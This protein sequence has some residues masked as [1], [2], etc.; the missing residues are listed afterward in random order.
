MSDSS[1][2]IEKLAGSSNYDLW[3]I[4]MESVLVEKGYYEVMT[5]NPETLHLDEVEKLE[6]NKLA[7]KATAQIRLALGNGPLLQTK[8][9][10]NPYSL[11]Q[12][13]KQLYEPKGFSSEFLILKELFSTTLRNSKYD[14]EDYL[15]TIKRLND[16]LNARE[17]KLPIKVIIAWVLN[18]L[19]PDYENTVAIITQQIRQNKEF[20]LEELF[21]YLI[22]EAR[23]LKSNRNTSTTT[24][25]STTTSD[26]ALVSTTTSISNKKQNQCSFCK[27]N[28][29]IEDNCFKKNPRLRESY[30]KKQLESINN[31]TTTNSSSDISNNIQESALNTITTHSINYTEAKNISITT[32]SNSI[33]WVLDSGASTHICADKE[34]FHTIRPT[35]S[36]IKWGSNNAE[37]KASGIGEIKIKFKNTNRLASLNQVL[38][39]PE[40]GV[41]LISLGII[42][43]KG[44]MAKF[45]KNSCKIYN[46][47]FI[48]AEG[49]YINNLSIFETTTPL[50]TSYNKTSPSIILNT[51]TLDSKTWHERLGHIGSNALKELENSTLGVH[52]NN[53]EF[54]TKEC[55]T[56]IQAKITKKVSKKPIEKAEKYLDKVYSDIGGPIFPSTNRGYKYYVTLLDSNTRYLEV[57]L[58]STKDEIKDKLPLI[59]KREENISENRLKVFFSDNAK[60]YISFG[61]NYLL[62]KGVKHETSA[63]YSPDQNGIAERINRTLFNK[64]RALLIQANLAKKYWGEALLSAV[65]LYN[66]TP[67]SSINYKT[68]YELK[69]KKKPDISSLKKWGSLC[70]KREDSSLIS[71]LDS[72]AT[73]YYIIGY[74][75]NQYKLL[76]PSTNRILWARDVAIIEGIYW[77]SD[78]ENHIELLKDLGDTETL[79]TYNNYN[80]PNS[81]TTSSSSTSNIDNKTSEN[82]SNTSNKDTSTNW[83]NFYNELIEESI[84]NTSITSEISNTSNNIT[85]PTSYKQAIKGLYQDNWKKAMESELEDH[86]KLN[87]WTLV[88]RPKNQPILGGRWVYKAKLNPDSSI[89]KFKARWVAKGYLQHYGVNYLETFANTVR[90]DIYRLLFA[91][92]SK[93][94]LKIYQWDVKLAFVN[95]PIDTTIYIEL[96]DGYYSSSNN[97][98]KNEDKDIVCL[99]NKALYGLKQSARQW[100]LYLTS[101]LAK[102][103][104]YP[105]TADPSVFINK[106]Q[107]IVIVTHVDDFLVFSTTKELVDSLYN[108]LLP[109]LEINN[110]GIAKYFLGIEIDY[111]SDNSIIIH[112]SAFINKLLNKFNKL[113]LKPVKNPSQQGVK[114]IKNDEL[115]TPSN[116]QQ[117]QQ[118]IGSLIYLT[119]CTRP[120]LAYAVGVLARFMSNPSLDHSKALDIIWAY[121]N[122]SKNYGLYYKSSSTLKLAGFSDSDWGG[123]LVSRKST[124]GWIYTIDNTAIGWNSKLQKTVAL[125]SAEAEY[126][127]LKETIKH[128]IYLNSI[129]SLVPILNQEIRD[130]KTIFTDSQSAIELAKNPVHHNRTKHIDIQYHF[131]RSNY[132]EGVVDLVYCPTNILLA[133]GLTKSI[134]NPKFNEFVKGLGLVNIYELIA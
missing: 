79:N 121:L 78:I 63:P 92:A 115:A 22:D 23:R 120:D 34:L 113:Q 4:R 71:K 15:A 107:N 76:N 12:A 106:N 133:D 122:Y 70:Y 88:K 68:P 118:E 128:N 74:G 85:E 62:N 35:D 94:K 83:N 57:E 14:I 56:C 102:F 98:N 6:Y 38:Y 103:D 91:L 60:E 131:V 123:D 89:N 10:T 43:D 20:N 16:D 7:L 130:K 18:N 26:T 126:M 82:T 95:S 66:R 67:N 13:I 9:V 108:K 2:R 80:I 65:Y 55:T 111:T 125:S 37:I 29:H 32:S 101:K 119:T 42:R 90:P 104:F 40:L 45:D 86:K 51:N 49:I 58:L 11:W 129:I 24:T 72:R 100:Q 46:N 84:L 31:T 114:L 59:I 97:I 109:E 50:H 28:G 1:L 3:S 54:S 77:K 117:F 27:R 132:L 96:P 73:P 33:K 5:S 64:V 25:S 41:N 30:Y 99:L 105:I 87:T 93:L 124:T 110:L 53:T 75:S 17:I 21:S 116:I 127:A 52:F 134:S 81:D 44:F 8:N 47:E 19:S 36:I 69:Y 39:V 48:L 112:Q 61:E